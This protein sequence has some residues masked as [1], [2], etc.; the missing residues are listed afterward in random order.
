[1]GCFELADP[2]LTPASRPTGGSF[3]VIVTGG[4]GLNYTMEATRDFGSWFTVTNLTMTNSI[5]RSSLPIL[6]GEQHL[7]YRAALTQ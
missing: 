1:M 6:S 2:L 4:R 7:F 3:G 5:M